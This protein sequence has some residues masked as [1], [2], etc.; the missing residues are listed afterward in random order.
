VQCRQLQ[1]AQ[2]HESPTRAASEAIVASAMAEAALLREE[3][4]SLRAR[5]EQLERE[6]AAK[7]ARSV[8][9]LQERDAT[10][11]RL[12]AAAAATAPS[13]GGADRGAGVARVPRAVEEAPASH[14]LPLGSAERRTSLTPLASAGAAAG[15]LETE[16]DAAELQHA[17]QLSRQQEAVLK[18]TIRDLQRTLSELSCPAFADTAS[19]AYLR[20]TVLQYIAF[21]HADS[22]P[23]QAASAGATSSTTPNRAGPP[24]AAH[25]L[26]PSQ[27]TSGPSTPGSQLSGGFGASAS[28][29]PEAGASWWGPLLSG[30]SKAASLASGRDPAVHSAQLAGL[31]RVLATL[32]RFSPEECARV[33]CPPVVVQPLPAGLVAARAAS[34]SLATPKPARQAASRANGYGDSAR[35]PHGSSASWS[36]VALHSP[37]APS[38]GGQPAAGAAMAEARVLG[39]PR[40]LVDVDALELT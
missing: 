38:V 31:E 33:G 9:L 5:V 10:I 19:A 2:M 18:A 13:G 3:S 28:S 32:L 36:E 34:A 37:P 11:A 27:T 39:K 16:E 12:Q 24:A 29:T 40:R 14:Q 23:A 15:E 6:A 7:S 25:H 30:L 26:V 22:A 20:R 17:L 35:P 1:E 4:A 21:A 8:A